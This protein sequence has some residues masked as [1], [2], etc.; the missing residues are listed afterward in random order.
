MLGLVVGLGLQLDKLRRLTKYGSLP[1]PQSES[2]RDS[3]FQSRSKL[4]CRTVGF[5]TRPV[6]TSPARSLGLGVPKLP[7]GSIS[8][9]RRRTSEAL[10]PDVKRS[11]LTC[12]HLQRASLVA[13]RKGWTDHNCCT[14]TYSTYSSGTPAAVHRS[15]THPSQS[16][17][18][19]CDRMDSASPASRLRVQAGDLSQKTY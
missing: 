5:A 4:L 2:K 6:P 3:T 16:V 19:I 7:A 14:A 15:L 12:L 9:G 17:V 8:R 18:G 1:C 13:R 10:T 11:I